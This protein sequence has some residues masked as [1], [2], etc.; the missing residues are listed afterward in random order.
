MCMANMLQALYII[1]YLRAFLLPQIQANSMEQMTA[2][3]NDMMFVF[4]DTIRADDAQQTIVHCSYYG[5]SHVTH[6]KI[7]PEFFLDE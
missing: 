6:S 3:G 4:A 2:F 1:L 5:N 7:S